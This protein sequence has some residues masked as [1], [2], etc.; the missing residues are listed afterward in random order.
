[1]SSIE[2]TNIQ[3]SNLFSPLDVALIYSP[4]I[5]THHYHF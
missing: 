3:L 5:E 1:M 4:L 2:H